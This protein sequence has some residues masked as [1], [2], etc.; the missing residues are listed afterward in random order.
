MGQLQI[1]HNRG[2]GQGEGI[3]IQ[4]EKKG[5]KINTLSKRGQSR[6]GTLWSENRESMKSR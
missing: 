2:A 1:N 4:G 6:K 5:V 3:G